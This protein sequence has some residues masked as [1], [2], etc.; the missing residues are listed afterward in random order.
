MFLS[1]EMGMVKPD[2]EIYTTMIANIGLPAEQILFI[3]DN[4]INVTGALQTGL[5]AK[6]ARGFNE[7]KAVLESAGLLT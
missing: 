2:A 1:Y 7:V 6:Q 4:Q 3:D 5:T